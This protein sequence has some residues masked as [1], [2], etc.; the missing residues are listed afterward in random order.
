MKKILVIGGGFA[1][2]WSAVAAVRRLHETGGEAQVTLLNRDAYH[3]IRVRYYEE[4]LSDTLVPLAQVLDPVGVKLVI[5]E[6][7]GIDTAQ[8]R[9]DV[10]MEDGPQELFY[11][12]LV[13]ASGSQL[14][15]PAI[16]GLAEQAFNI[17][18]HAAAMRLQTHMRQLAVAPQRAG[19]LTAVVVG[20]GATGV[21]LAC[22][23]PERLRKAAAASGRLDADRDVRVILADREE[24]VC[25]QLG[26]ARPVIERACDALGVERL[27]NVAIKAISADGIVLGNGAMIPAATVAWCAGMRASSLNS[28]ISTELDASGRLYVDEHLKVKG[29][30]NVFAAGD[31]AHMLIDGT[32]PSVMSCQHARP[33]GRFAGHNA[34]NDLVGEQLEPLNID[35]YTNIIDL[36]PWGAV[37]AEGWTRTVRSEGIDA[38]KTKTVVNRERIYPPLSG[39]KD[40]ILAASAL[41][42]QRPPAMNSKP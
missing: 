17:D 7:T 3:G 10:L 14:T 12:K 23:L 13:M 9:V 19:W 38:K 20:A 11:D 6:V 34:V 27:S 41:N 31:A 16:P 33:M 42:L 35:W 2:L 28:H 1:G 32:A 26:E 37:Y 21:E 40:A 4:D 24:I 36:G 22:E 18:T 29:V 30:A 39:D 8:Q 15:L 5:G 25:S